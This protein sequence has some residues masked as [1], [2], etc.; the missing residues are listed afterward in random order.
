MHH[1][2]EGAKARRGILR[3]FVP[4]VFLLSFALAS[5]ARADAGQDA[6][7]AALEARDA[8]NDVIAARA[9]LLPLLDGASG[10]AHQ[11][12][13]AAR[14]SFLL[15]E[16]DERARRY[17]DALG[18][19]RDVLR[20]DPGNYYAATA[21]ARVESLA[22]YDRGYAEL[23]RLDELRKDP[24]KQG[25]ARALDA[26]VIE[27]R[28]WS[29]TPN[30]RAEALLFAAAAYADRVGDGAKAGEVALL[31]AR[32]PANDA[33]TRARAFEIYYAAANARR[34]FEGIRANVLGDPSAPRALV[35]LARRDARRRTLHRAALAIGLAAG[36]ATLVAVVTTARRRRLRVALEVLLDRRAIGFLALT[37]LGGAAIAEAWSPEMGAHF[38]TFGTG[39]L[40][41]HALAAA[42]RGGFGD[43]ARAVRLLGGATA[44][45]CV[46]AAAY[47][48][49]ERG[50]LRGA[51]LLAGFGL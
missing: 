44:A 39:L 1:G 51:P 14:A 16:L 45:A 5:P 46:L 30:V 11:R 40:G 15:G 34:D 10:D 21:R 6:I 20:I 31:V 32:E 24:A 18:R 9:T 47:L 4:S 17:E 12:D 43:R 28:G 38:L 50:E 36:L 8:R 42:W 27:A 41:A 33:T 26:L 48:A 19:Y 29:A 13:L 3:G 2:L 35:R 23:A 37:V 49:L 22:Q 25:D 7:A